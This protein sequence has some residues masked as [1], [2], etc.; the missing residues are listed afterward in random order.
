[1]PVH[2]SKFVDLVLQNGIIFILL[3]WTKGQ[4]QYAEILVW[5]WT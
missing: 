2:L 5:S 4:G 1:M 3:I